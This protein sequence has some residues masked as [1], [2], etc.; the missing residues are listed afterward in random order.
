MTQ[1]G[2]PYV[3]LCGTKNFDPYETFECGQCFR[4]EK[5]AEAD[6]MYTAGFRRIRV[7][8]SGGDIILH[9]TDEEEFRSFWYGFFTL[10]LDYEKI[11]NSFPR[12]GII[13]AAAE[14]C[15]GIRLLRQN[16]FETVISFII[17][18]NN[19]I[20]R[21]KKIVEKLC[22]CFGDRKTDCFGSFYA[23][24]S[25]ERLAAAEE[26]ELAP[27]RAGFRAKYI[28]DAAKKSASGRIDLAELSV[29]PAEE[30][31][32]RLME[33]KGVGPKVAAC[34]LLFGFSRFDAFPID[35]W[36]KK[37]MEKYYPELADPAAY[38]G[39]FAGIAQQYL[40]H[41]ERIY[42]KNSLR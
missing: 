26:I 18:Q 17:S 39:V 32:K 13:D 25:V 3:K 8:K 12:D 23:F 19:N 41:Y 31:K 34:A 14:K 22:E 42:G 20:P 36:V 5:L 33:I 35:V 11:R 21:I 10:D 15:G 16:G 7:Q 28:S 9:N 6:Y 38:F 4:Y 27:I 40:F 30:A 24:P 29:I 2:I 1:A 37:V